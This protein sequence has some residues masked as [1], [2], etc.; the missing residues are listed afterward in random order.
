M[1]R[2]I[3]EKTLEHW[4]SMYVAHRFPM[5][6]LW[7]PTAGEDIRVEDFGTMPGKAFYLEV[8]VPEQSP[9]QHV[10]TINL[11]QLLA[12]VGQPVPVYYVIPLPPWTGVSTPP[13]S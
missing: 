6:A 7:W 13:E 2:S 11:P 9:S 10:T 1:V 4:A 8:K 3:P 12:Y 5:A